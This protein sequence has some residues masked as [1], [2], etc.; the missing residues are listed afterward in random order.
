MSVE[1]S[2]PTRWANKIFIS[3]FL[4]CRP[5]SLTHSVFVFIIALSEEKYIYVIKKFDFLVRKNFKTITD[6]LFFSISGK[7]V[8]SNFVSNYIT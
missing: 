8:P 7:L 3:I 2:Q 4:I 5:Q 1:S 6:V